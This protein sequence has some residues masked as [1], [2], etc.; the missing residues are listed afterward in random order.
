MAKQSKLDHLP[1][2]VKAELIEKILIGGERYQDLSQWLLDKHGLKAAASSIWR[3]SQTILLKHGGLVELGI[4]IKTIA[5]HS[6]ELEELGAYLVRQMLL[7]KIIEEKAAAIFEILS[8][9]EASQ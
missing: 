2:P 9:S 1:G 8:R 5:D 6:D 7:T 3:F 4:P